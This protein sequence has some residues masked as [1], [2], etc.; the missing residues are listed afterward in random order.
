MQSTAF[1]PILRNACASPTEVVVLPFSGGGRVDRRDD[2]QLAL[3][4]ADVVS[5]SATFALYLP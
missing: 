3:S 5:S 2:H 4:R 1:V